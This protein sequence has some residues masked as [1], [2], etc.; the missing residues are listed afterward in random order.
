M[1]WRLRHS[2]LISCPFDWDRKPVI[3]WL[4]LYE[5]AAA[6]PKWLIVVTEVPGNPG[7]SISNQF[8]TVQSAVSHQFGVDL[9]SVAWFHA[10][11]IGCSGD[12]DKSSWT[13]IDARGYDEG[14]DVDRT[15]VELLIRQTLPDL[16]EHDDLYGKVLE[17]GGGVW[18]EA[19]LPIFE[20]VPVHELPPPHLPYS[21]EHHDRFEA[22]LEETPESDEWMTRNLE[23]G[24]RFL[25]SL[26]PG[27]RAR[28]RYHKDNWLAI[29]DESVRVLREVGERAE[30]DA[31]IAAARGSK[32][33][34]K[35]EEWLISLFSSPILIGGGS[36]TNGQHRA[37]AL[38][39]SGA[40]CAAIHV[41][42]EYLGEVCVDWM[43]GGGG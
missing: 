39:F 19:Y 22:I 12:N 35:D 3:C 42:D 34:N 10:W 33:G 23:A 14:I 18:D 7:G 37:C 31:Y 15:D 9:D 11:P 1:E 36:F 5:D 21:C 16:P 26:T 43:Y 27:D 6:S 32:L 38:R 20:A 40:K 28:C 30:T 13:K 2:G 29:A 8:E 4:R 25:S 24:R 41:D 17:L